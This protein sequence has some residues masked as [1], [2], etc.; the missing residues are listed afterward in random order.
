[1][2]SDYPLTKHHISENGIPIFSVVF[3]VEMYKPSTY[4][5]LTAGKEVTPD[6]HCRQIE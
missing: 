2:K 1:M 3:V 4:C 6:T 5:I